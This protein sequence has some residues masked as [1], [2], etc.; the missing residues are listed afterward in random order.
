MPI[1]AIV[2]SN[3]QNCNPIKSVGF[4]GEQKCKQEAKCDKASNKLKTGVFI[5]TLVG[6]AA[7]YAIMLKRFGYSTNIGK[8]FKSPLKEWSIFKVKFDEEKCQVQKL[9]GALAAGSVGGGLIGGLVFDDKKNT[10]AK[11]RESIIQIVGNIATPLF[12]VWGGMAGFKKL[13]PKIM[14]MLPEFK[15]PKTIDIAKGIP[16]V[17]ASGLSLIAG[18]FLGNKVG[19][20]I[21]KNAFRVDDNR[22]IKIS[23]MSP[24][25]DDLCLAISLVA[26]NTKMGANNKF[27]GRVSRL[28]PA[29]LVVAGVSTGIAKEKYNIMA[30][31]AVEKVHKSEIKFYKQQFKANQSNCKMS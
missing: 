3:S 9:V 20:V 11:L 22:K 10:N 21:N 1:K 14:K 4:Q 18:I 31:K 7:A 24:H 25:I 26:A 12:C 23:D 19:N 28:I 15:N 30:Q 16:S 17:L 6:T 5:T 29:A 2:N 8:A 13:E 27:A